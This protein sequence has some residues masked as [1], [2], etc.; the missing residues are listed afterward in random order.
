MILIP[1]SKLILKE[2]DEDLDPLLIASQIKAESSFNPKAVSHV[3]ATGLM[4]VMPETAKWLGF[5]PAH[6]FNPKLN[7][8]VGVKFDKWLLKYWKRRVK[9][10]QIEYYVLMLAS[11]NA[12]QGKV[13]KTQFHKTLKLDVLP[14]ETQDYIKRILRYYSNYLI[15]RSNY[16]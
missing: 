8:K 2:C 11:Y 16:E 9:K 4:Q 7:I 1:F 10:K 6:L 5:N 14:R 15:R 12:G 3:G 13:K